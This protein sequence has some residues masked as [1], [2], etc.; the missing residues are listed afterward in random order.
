MHWSQTKNR[1]VIAEK[2]RQK[3]LGKLNAQ[4]KPVAT[5]GSAHAWLFRQRHLKKICAHC[6]SKATLE[7]ALKKGEIHARN[8]A[9]YLV[10]CDSCHKKY[11]YTDERRGKLKKAM[12]G[13][14]ITWSDKIAKATK[15]RIVTQVTKDKIREWQKLHPQPRDGKGRFKC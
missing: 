15:G 9:H 10:L 7:W 4:W 3:K 1:E 14:K 6:G 8:I 11:D 2:I 5:Y 13:R 12:T